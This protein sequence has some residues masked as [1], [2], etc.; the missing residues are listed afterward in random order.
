MPYG[1]SERTI[2][3][4]IMELTDGEHIGGNLFPK[5]ELTGNNNA[6]G[7]RTT[8][9]SPFELQ[10]HR[11]RTLTTSQGSALLLGARFGVH[12]FVLY[13]ERK[14]NAPQTNGALRYF[15]NVSVC[16]LTVPPQ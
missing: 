14:T 2:N 9:I 7:C 5:T 3:A 10:R 13:C 1:E 6:H 15:E 4:Y 16:Q 11:A 12:F 8:R